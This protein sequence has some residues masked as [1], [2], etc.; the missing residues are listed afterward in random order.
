[1]DVPG[2]WVAETGGPLPGTVVAPA[3]VVVVATGEVVVAA[4]LRVV[5]VVRR[6]SVVGDDRGAMVVVGTS[7]GTGAGV[8][9]LWTCSTHTTTNAAARTRVERRTPIPNGRW[10]RRRFRLIQLGLMSQASARRTLMAGGT[11]PASCRA[12]AARSR[13]SRPTSNCLPGSVRAIMRSC[14]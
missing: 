10:M 5:V 7:T 3:T 6:R 9:M 11:T 13:S 14:R 8:G 4:G 12:R 1:M 2:T